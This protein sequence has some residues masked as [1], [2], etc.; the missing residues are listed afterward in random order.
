MIEQLIDWAT[1]QPLVRAMILTST[2]AVPNAALDRFSDYDVIL[3]LQDVQP[4]FAERDW[5]AAFGRVLVLYRDPL[6]TDHGYEKSAYVVQYEDGLK[7]DFTLWP[8]GLL[9][10]VVA[11]P[12]LPPEFDAGYQVLLDKD[13]LT[14][15]LQPPSYQAYIPQPPTV[16]AYLEAIEV[17]LLEAIYVAKLLWRDDLMAAKEI[18]DHMMKQEH[19]LPLLEWHGEIEHGW[20]IKP[21]PYGRRLKQW[22]RPDLWAAVER[23]YAGADVEE[24]W[25]A[26]F[27]SIDLLHKVASEVGEHL[28]YAYPAEMEQRTRAYLHKMKALVGHD[29]LLKNRMREA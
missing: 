26:L 28:G 20:S 22:I 6:L 2:R 29:S 13:D 27:N 8:V 19:L 14:V 9:Q 11:E 24:N 12:H 1:D 23:T 21:G 5:L 10:R 18:L 3:A 25:V 16:Q 17:C 7:I 15:G 4:F